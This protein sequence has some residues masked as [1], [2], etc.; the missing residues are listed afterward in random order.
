MGSKKPETP[1]LSVSSIRSAA[2]N[3]G[4]ATRTINEEDKKDHAINGIL[5]KGKSGCLHF[6]MV[7]IKLIEPRTWEIPIIFRP[8]IHMSAAGA[9]ALITEYGG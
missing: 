8:K 7:T 2:A 1:S 3:V 9:G 6:R 4:I 5:L